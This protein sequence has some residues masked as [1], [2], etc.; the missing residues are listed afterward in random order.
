MTRDEVFREP[1]KYIIDFAFDDTVAAVFPDMIRRSVPGYEV[2]VPTTGL[3]AARAIADCEHRLIYDLGSS[4]GA[5]SL[6]TL[7]ALDVLFTE[8]DE[9]AA[10]TKIIGVDNAPAMVKRASGLVDDD[11]LTFVEED[12]LELEFAPCGAVLMNYVLQFLP[13]T[14][15]LRLLSDI[16]EKMDDQGVLIVSE[17]IRFEDPIEQAQ[18][19]A[20]HLDFK[21]ANAYSEIEISQKRTA[22]ENVM[23]ID[24]PEIHSARFKEAGFT[25]VQ[26]WF[27]CMNWA[28]FLVRP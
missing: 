26:R 5:T 6:A 28:S 9:T 17:K 19:E 2:V 25:T 12:I 23:I 8:A 27:Q 4:L 21:R 7:R 20:A 11:R 1:Q 3:L 24:T 22:L 16:R 13:P 10:K 14:E 18:C 15:R